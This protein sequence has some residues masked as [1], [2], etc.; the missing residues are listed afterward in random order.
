MPPRFTYWTIILDGQPTAFRSA[1]REQ[2]LPTLKQLQTKNPDAVLRWFAHGRVWESPDEVRQ[3]RERKRAEARDAALKEPRGRGWR[4]G[5]DHKDPREKFKRE[6]FQAH[7]RRERK[8]ANLAAPPHEP[9]GE[10][11]RVAPSHK[12]RMPRLRKPR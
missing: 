2:L 4:P 8:A 11:G 9:T 6:T 12:T 5:G 3:L 10:P 1:E 7:K